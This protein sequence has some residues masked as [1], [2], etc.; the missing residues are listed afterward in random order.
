SKVWGF[1]RRQ[2]RLPTEDEIAEARARV[3]MQSVVLDA[4][5]KT[6]RFARPGVALNLGSIGKGYALDRAAKPLREAG[7]T[8]L[9]TA[10]SSSM[11]AIGG[12]PDG[13]GFTV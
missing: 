4:A 5:T 6:V 3:G 12:G 9:L 1:L 8:A 7:A 13:R 10:G 2:G 11:L